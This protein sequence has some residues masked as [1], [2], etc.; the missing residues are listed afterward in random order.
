MLPLLQR[1]GMA[2]F[3][4]TFKYAKKKH[5]FEKISFFA[6]RNNAWE[7]VSLAISRLSIDL[8]VS[9]YTDR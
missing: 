6:L 4:W 3:P 2:L 1:G 5:N 8:F 7:H 9:F